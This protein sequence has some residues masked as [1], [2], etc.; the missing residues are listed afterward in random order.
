M[1]RLASE[2][3]RN[4]EMRIAR[5]EKSANPLVLGDAIVAENNYTGGISFFRGR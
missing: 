4:L 3:I 2:V 1:R 5:L